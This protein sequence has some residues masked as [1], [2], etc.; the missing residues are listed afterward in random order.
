MVLIW[1]GLGHP[2]LLPLIG[3]SRELF[4]PKIALV[5][6]WMK[7]GNVLQYLEKNPRINRLHLVS[8]LTPLWLNGY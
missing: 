5:T 3:I 2:Y 1:L 6:P 4:P 7:N 8:N